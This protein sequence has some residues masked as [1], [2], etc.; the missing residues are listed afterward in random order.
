M[1]THCAT[2]RVG[3]QLTILAQELAGHD[4]FV[5]E[6][7]AL[8]NAGGEALLLGIVDNRLDGDALPLSRSLGFLLLGAGL[9]PL[10]PPQGAAEVGL[11]P[12]LIVKV[13][14]IRCSTREPVSVMDQPM[15]MMSKGSPQKHA[16]RIPVAAVAT[17]AVT[18]VEVE[19]MFERIA[20]RWRAGKRTRAVDEGGEEGGGGSRQPDG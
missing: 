8:L 13:R 4:L 7:L 5:K 12:S 19:T 9:F 3:R 6:G 16:P 15:V 20:P 10:G 17:E 2:T 1:P 18:I 14:H 11:V